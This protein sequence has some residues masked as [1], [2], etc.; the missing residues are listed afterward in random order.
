MCPYHCFP[1]PKPQDR[2]R[3]CTAPAHASLEGRALPSKTH[4]INSITVAL[5]KPPQTIPGLFVLP[6]AR[7]ATALTWPA[8]GS[9]TQVPLAAEA[10]FPLPS[11]KHRHAQ[12]QW[13]AE[14]DRHVLFPWC[15]AQ[16]LILVQ[17]SH[18]CSVLL[19]W[20]GPWMLG[21]SLAVAPDS[22]SLFLLF[23]GAGAAAAPSSSTLHGPHHLQQQAGCYAAPTAGAQ[24]CTGAVPGLLLVSHRKTF[25]H[26]LHSS[27]S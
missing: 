27:H 15:C 24:G 10:A 8:Q 17:M 12:P 11:P 19:S 5:P 26:A 7:Q 3:S 6:G 18:L 16:T 21:T 1:L 25:P 20:H 23:P 4:P 9:R 22:I 2:S 13:A 14:T